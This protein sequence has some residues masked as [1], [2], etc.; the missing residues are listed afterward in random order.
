M[1]KLSPSFM[2]A[3]QEGFLSGILKT[4][5]AD[6]DLD[7]QIRDNYINLYF[8]G[9]SLLKLSQLS[10]K[11]YKV[12]IHSKFIKALAIPSYI[13]SEKNTKL[14]LQAIPFLKENISRIG[15]TSLE[16]EYE[17]LI[18]RA[19]NR[20]KRNNSEYFFVD[21]QYE[22]A[23]ERFDLMGFYWSRDN[24]KK[25]QIVSPCLIEVKFALNVDI[26]DVHEQL[27]SYYQLVKENVEKIS[28]DLEQ[29]FHQ[30]LELGLYEQS[31]S[32]LEAMKTLRFSQELSSF[33]FILVLVDYNP[34]SSR[35]NMDNL[36]ELPF[37]KQI[38]IFSSGFAMWQ[39]V[40]TTV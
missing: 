12:D 3:L 4:V 36:K 22:L 32:R 34:F 19:N 21:R 24:R 13:E 26:S 27:Q 7:F 10:D 17:Q 28:S 5:H 2:K 18:I 31:K 1:R 16:I 25:H 35:L 33:Q 20:E 11:K 8:K 38:K 39:K 6:K 23:S 9:N 30:Q 29:S 37:S 14:F 40:L 15:K